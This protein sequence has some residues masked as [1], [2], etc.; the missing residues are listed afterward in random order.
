ML[1]R[2]EMVESLRKGV[3]EVTFTKADG[4]KRVMKCTLI[5]S[6][7]PSYEKKTERTTKIKDDVVAVYDLD[8]AG[9]RSFRAD[10][11]N[12]FLEVAA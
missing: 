2:N 7:L 11:V 3:Y 8:N 5:E 12:L 9:W 10:S 1:T 6:M 4:S